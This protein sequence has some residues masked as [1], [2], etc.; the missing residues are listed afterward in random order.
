MLSPTAECM[1]RSSFRRTSPSFE[2]C[3]R[4][5]L[6]P[7]LVDSFSLASIA[8]ETVQPSSVVSSPKARS[9]LG[10]LDETYT[11]E[12]FPLL[13]VALPQR[14]GTPPPIDRVHAASFLVSGD[15]PELLQPPSS[16]L[17]HRNWRFGP[18][19]RVSPP[20]KGPY[21]QHPGASASRSPSLR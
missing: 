17:S 1:S 14:E 12:L 4:G 2:V 3:T 5:C 19:T 18:L 15:L 10:S 13:T 7:L 9:P 20:P 8:S 21:V 16:T 11:F 6:M